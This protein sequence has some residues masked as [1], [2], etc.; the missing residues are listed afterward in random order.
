[1]G[2]AKVSRTFVYGDFF[3]GKKSRSKPALPGTQPFAIE[4]LREFS[5]TEFIGKLFYRAGGEW[6]PANRSMLH[7]SNWFTDYQKSLKKIHRGLN[8]EEEFQPTKALFFAME[9]SG[10]WHVQNIRDESDDSGPYIAV[11]LK[12]GKPA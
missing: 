7:N 11:A 5:S 10:I 4:I 3:L 2:Y 6:F 1:M 12:S 8:T 9:G